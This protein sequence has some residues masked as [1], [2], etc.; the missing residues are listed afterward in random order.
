LQPLDA[1]DQ[2]LDQ[3]VGGLLADGYCDRHRHASLARR[4]VARTYQCIDSLIHVGVGHHDHVVLGAAK[5]LHALSVRA[6]SRLDV[7]RDVGRP[8]ES[9]RLARL[10]TKAA[11]PRRVV[12]AASGAKDEVHARLTGGRVAATGLEGLFVLGEC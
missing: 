1:R 10:A 12:S 5:T 3:Y 9:D 11:W 8:R 4:A 6:T 7:L 2:L